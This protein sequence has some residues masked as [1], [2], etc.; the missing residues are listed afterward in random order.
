MRICR[1]SSFVC[2]QKNP[3]IAGTQLRPRHLRMARLSRKERCAPR[4]LRT[5]TPCTPL[6]RARTR[7]VLRL[8]RFVLAL[9]WRLRPNLLP[10]GSV[11]DLLHA[12]LHSLKCEY[13]RGSRPDLWRYAPYNLHYIPSLCPAEHIPSALPNVRNVTI[14]QPIGECP[15]RRL[16][17]AHPRHRC[18]VGRIARRTLISYH[19]LAPS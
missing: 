4:T 17:C 12:S 2:F 8:L 19:S 5:P 3:L 18:R 6:N 15:A 11:G 1:D 13:S 16:F 9:Q 14:K 10:S 7:T